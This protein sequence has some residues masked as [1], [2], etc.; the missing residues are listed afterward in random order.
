MIKAVKFYIGVKGRFTIRKSKLNSDIA[1]STNSVLSP[2]FSNTLDWF[3]S[4]VYVDLQ[5]QFKNWRIELSTPINLHSYTI[6]DAP[7]TN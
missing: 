5:T 2:D 1:T 4:K 3:R 6:K 7:S